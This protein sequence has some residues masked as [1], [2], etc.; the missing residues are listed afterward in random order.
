MLNLIVA[1]GNL[2][3]M[4][5]MHSFLDGLPILL[6]SMKDFAKFPDIEETGQTFEENVKI[7]ARICFDFFKQPVLA[8]DSGLEVLALDNEPGVYSA[9]YAGP[10]A[11]DQDNN[12]FLLHKM[13][14]LQGEKRKARFVCTLCYKDRQIEKIFTGTTEGMILEEYKGR[15]GFGYDPLF[16]IP[17]IGKTYA[18]LST[19]QK[20][21]FSHRGKALRKL[22]HFLEQ[23]RYLAL[24]ES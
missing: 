21:A 17:E 24:P 5:E 4:E 1:T 10:G 22:V 6:K 3:K 13:K 19:E 15:Q 18:Q 16:Y 8:D 23:K 2:H 7:K 9:R 14:G 11:N 12:R 20:N